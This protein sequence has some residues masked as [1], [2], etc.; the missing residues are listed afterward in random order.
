MSSNNSASLDN[1]FLSVSED[2][3][4]SDAFIDSLVSPNRHPMKLVLSS[5]V[6]ETAEL[7]KSRR[8]SAPV[9]PN[10]TA[11]QRLISPVIKERSLSSCSSV[12]SPDGDNASGILW[13]VSEGEEDEDLDTPT[14]RSH[15]GPARPYTDSL[16]DITSLSHN[17]TS[18][19][20]Q[21]PGH[22]VGSLRTTS[23]GSVTQPFVAQY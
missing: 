7:P 17:Q 16:D 20:L 6:I 12:R 8:I 23:G 22:F 13:M 9:G 14:G 19:H 15:S 1:I 4:S 10:P 2:S 18:S 21:P 5:P 11:T 3:S